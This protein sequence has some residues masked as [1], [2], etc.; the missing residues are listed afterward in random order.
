MKNTKYLAILFVALGLTACGGGGGSGSSNSTGNNA[1]GPITDNGQPSTPIDTEQPNQGGDD[2]DTALNYFMLKDFKMMPANE[3]LSNSVGGIGGPNKN[4][5]ASPI[6]EAAGYNGTMNNGRVLC[7]GENSNTVINLHQSMSYYWSVPEY[8]HYQ[9]FG[10]P[11][12]NADNAGFF[13]VYNRNVDNCFISTFF[14]NYGD[15]LTGTM[16]NGGDYAY[17]DVISSLALI[18]VLNDDPV[19]LINDITNTWSS[20]SDV[21]FNGDL[22]RYQCAY[23]EHKGRLSVDTFFEEEAKIIAAIKGSSYYTQASNEVDAYL[24]E[25]TNHKNYKSLLKSK[26]RAK[27]N[28]A[29]YHLR[30][31]GGELEIS[32]IYDLFKDGNDLFTSFGLTN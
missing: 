28:V 8:N 30:I 9:Q 18:K 21:V 7:D 3:L 10:G 2:E 20:C 4:I 12:A 1:T 15:E 29:L 25:N 22:I 11:G 19:V 13:L 24:A 26:D 5:S 6:I 17:L 27:L 14:V 16:Y 31:A 23:E 32:E